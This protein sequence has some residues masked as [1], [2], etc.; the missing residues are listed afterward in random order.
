LQKKESILNTKAKKPKTER[1]AFLESDTEREKIMFGDLMPEE[2]YSI[3][4]KDKPGFFKFSKPVFFRFLFL[5]K[6]SN[7]YI[8]STTS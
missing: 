1:F 8:Q 7:Q 5:R 3:T 6:G 4:L 2:N